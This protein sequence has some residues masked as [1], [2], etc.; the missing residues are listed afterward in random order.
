L[1]DDL[2]ERRICVL[3][4]T[5]KPDT[6]TL[7]RSAALEIIADL[8]RAGAQ[9]SASDPRADRVELAR[10]GAFSFF[11]NP[12][13][14]LGG[15]E[16]LLLMTPWK[17]YRDLDFAEVASRMKRRLLFDTANLWS[18]DELVRRGFEYYDI[19][20]GRKLKEAP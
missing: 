13:D 9:V 12:Y 14:A 16:A 10:Y 7:R 5:Y 2:S 1:G 6:S 11:E 19:G 3:G 18:A 15:A 8:T 17:Q 20:R 4:L